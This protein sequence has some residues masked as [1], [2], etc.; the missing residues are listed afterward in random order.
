VHP[1][2]VEDNE[3]VPLLGR[4]MSVRRRKELLQR[5]NALDTGTIEDACRAER[6]ARM[7]KAIQIEETLKWGRIS[8]DSL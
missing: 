3:L 5:L 1:V 4:I 8:A 7:R 6:E 2:L